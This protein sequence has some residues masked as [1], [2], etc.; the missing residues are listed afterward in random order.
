MVIILAARNVFAVSMTESSNAASFA[1][2]STAAVLAAMFLYSRL[3][4]ATHHAVAAR[5]YR[6]FNCPPKENGHESYHLHQRLDYV[7]HEGLKKWVAEIAALVTPER[8]RL[9]RRFAGRIRPPAP[10]TGLTPAPSSSSRS[11][12]IRSSPL[13][14]S[15]VARLGPHLHLLGEEGRRRP[16]S[17]TG[18]TGQGCARRS[19]ACSLAA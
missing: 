19:R 1:S 5:L 18:R 10:G 9:G 15:D 13:D 7:K 2:A 3:H 14:P 4:A 11:A 12:R 16:Q 17:T 6:F 8:V